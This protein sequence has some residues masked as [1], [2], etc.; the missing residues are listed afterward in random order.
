[1]ANA[2]N[3]LDI[4][5]VVLGGDLALFAD[6]YRPQIVHEVDTRVLARPFSDPVVLAVPPDHATPAF[7]AAFIALERVLDN[8]ARWAPEGR[9]LIS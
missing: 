4:T 6:E 1:M 5:T 9:G 3:L 7:G 8:P 2:C